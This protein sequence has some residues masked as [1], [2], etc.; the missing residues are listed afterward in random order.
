MEILRKCP[1][2]DTGDFALALKHAFVRID[3]LIQ[4]PEAQ[5]ELAEIS[6]SICKS[7]VLFGKQEGEDI[8]TNVG[9]TACVAIIA[10]TEIYVANAG[11]SRCVLS[12]GG[13]AIPLSEDHKPELEKERKRIE[14]AGGF[15]EEGRVK[16]VLNL[17]R[18]L[19]DLEYKR[20]KKLPPEQQMISAVPDVK[21]YKITPDTEFLI[22]ACD[23]LW[24]CFTNEKAV[25]TF[26]SEIW[27]HAGKKLIKTKLS[28]VISDVLDSI[29][30]K[31][32][33]N[34]GKKLSLVINSE[35]EGIGC[36]NMTC[37]IVQFLK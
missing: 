21:V 31:D 8:A 29:L 1:G 27:D 28:K 10:K 14:A 6:V 17:S 15:I 18:S 20:D 11:D 16:G 36:D 5:K 13:I 33:N 35:I 19:G 22:L 23:G 7:P 12:K 37:I 34:E 30:A 4:S 26:R 9:C 25:S 24:D 3:E 32:L 2:F